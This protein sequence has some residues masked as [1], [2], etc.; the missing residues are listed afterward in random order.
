[1]MAH[2]RDAYAAGDFP[3]E[4]WEAPQVDPAAVSHLEV[5]ALR[6]GGGLVHKQVQLLPELVA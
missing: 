3:E 4:E 2:N 6:V 1:M 5:E